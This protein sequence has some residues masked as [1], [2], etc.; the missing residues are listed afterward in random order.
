[1]EIKV[2]SIKKFQLTNSALKAFASVQIGPWVINDFR[3]VCQ[4][5]KKP[6][7]SAPQ[8]TWED[9]RGEKHHKPIVVVPDSLK[10]RIEQVVLDA[11]AHGVEPSQEDIPF[12]EDEDHGDPQY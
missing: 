10:D 8:S 9:D 12:G 5:G 2:L 1:M 6:W 3:V 11:W 7:V 4:E